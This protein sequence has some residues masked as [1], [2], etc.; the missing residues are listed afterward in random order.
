MKLYHIVVCLALAASLTACVREENPEPSASGAVELQGI[1][2]QIQ[3]GVQTRAG[4]ITALADY[5]GRSDFKGGDRVVFTEIRRTQTPLNYFTYPGS[6]NY[7]GIIY[8]AL[9]EGGWV[10]NVGAGEPERIYWTDAQSDHTFMAYGCPQVSGFDWK[11]LTVTSEQGQRNYYI[12]SLGDPTTSGII[13][14]SL[15]EQEQETH[16]AT[17]NNKLEYYN[18]KLENEDLVIAYDTRMQAEPGGS[19]A[20]ARHRS[21]KVHF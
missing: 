7:E 20:L 6:G 15:T 1:T 14:Y 3:S 2:A 18:P 16:Q 12:G 5:V 8:D 21:H 13:D 19:V 10:R 11:K 17:V 4:A 9:P